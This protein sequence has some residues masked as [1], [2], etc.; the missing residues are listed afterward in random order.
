M[1]FAVAETFMK[2]FFF[3][4][5]T[6]TLL[7][8]CFTT[9]QAQS[10]NDKL[11]LE[12]TTLR[13]Q[14]TTAIKQRDKKTLGEIYANDFTHIHASGQVDDKTKRIAALVSGDLTIESAEVSEISIRIYNKSTAVAVGN[15][16]I[17]DAE[18]KPTKYRWT[19]VYVKSGK[20]WQ[21][22]ASQATKIV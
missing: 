18:Q 21:I 20:K 14:L 4:L 22:A 10:K 15:S 7:L 5:T 12:I 19:I 9:L 16:T 1:M 11:V 2:R 13:Q 6:A 8:V 17:T 3:S